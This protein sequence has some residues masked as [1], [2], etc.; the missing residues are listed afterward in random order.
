MQVRVGRG[1]GRV[2]R[3]KLREHLLRVCSESGVA[4]MS[5]EVGDGRDMS[6]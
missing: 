2:S 5:A 4:F 6:E 3:R 1:Y